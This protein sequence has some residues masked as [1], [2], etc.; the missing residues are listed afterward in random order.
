MARR[1]ASRPE[2]LP[3]GFRYQPEFLTQE[4][5]RDVLEHIARLEFQP[6]NFRGYVARRRVV[7]YGWEYDFDSRSASEAPPIADFLLPL[8]E[9]A[10]RFAGIVPELLV[11]AVVTEYPMGAPI[12]WHRD[13]PQFELIIGI[14][15]GS[16]GRMRFKPYRGEGKLVSVNLE[17]RSIYVIQGEARWKFQHSMPPVETTR[18]SITFRTLRE[19]KQTDAA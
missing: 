1:V 16:A 13:V 3:A 8:R 4:E 19:K 14:S 9:R 2:E 18:H 6:F 15:L 11:E 12:G 17:P 5:E 7:E 10:A